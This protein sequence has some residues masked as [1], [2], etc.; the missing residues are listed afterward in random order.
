[1]KT[2]NFN[3]FQLW[4]GSS[5]FDKRPQSSEKP[6]K[7]HEQTLLWYHCKPLMWVRSHLVMS[8]LHIVSS[9]SSSYDRFNYMLYCHHFKAL[10][11][12]DVIVIICSSKSHCMNSVVEILEILIWIVLWN[13][14]KLIPRKWKK[15]P[16][17]FSE[18]ALTDRN[19]DFLPVDLC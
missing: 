11:T 17:L 14:L 6:C 18:T 4:L 8:I 15:K 19:K 5:C 10:K 16:W 12:V 7:H 1:M 2:V 13:L 3:N 9:S